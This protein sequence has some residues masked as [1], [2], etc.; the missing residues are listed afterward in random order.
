MSDWQREENLDAMRGACVLA[1]TVHHCIN[2][3]PGYS[4]LYWRFVSGAFPFLA[5]FLVTSILAGRANVGPDRNRLGLRLLV[6]G[7]KLIVLCIAL[8]IMLTFI[9]PL[10]GKGQSSSVLDLIGNVGFY[11]NYKSVAFS[12]LVPIGYTVVLGGLLLLSR[13]MHPGVIAI[14][15]GALFVYCVLAEWLTREEYYI[16]LLSLGVLGMA[17]GYASAWINRNL[18]SKAQLA[19][20]P[21]LAIQAVIAVT[22]KGEPYPIYYANTVASLLLIGFLVHLAVQGRIA[23]RY[24]IL[25]GQYSLLLY[26]F[27]IVVLVILRGQLSKLSIGSGVTGFWVALPLVSFAQLCLAAG[28]DWCRKQYPLTNRAYG[29]VFH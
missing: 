11:G 10:G 28:T 2:Y 14:L 20:A 5:G 13:I 22:G 25:L 6:R 4:L 24:L 19:V 21:W 23:V 15:G 7:L 9:F 18:L 16:P 27:Q 3:F 1:M 26:L 12:L 29:W 8:N 17:A